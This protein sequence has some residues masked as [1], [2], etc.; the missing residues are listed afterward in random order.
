[1]VDAEH[2]GGVVPGGVCLLGG[3]PGI[4]KST[5]LLQVLSA[6][7]D[8]SSTLYVTGE[9]SLAQVHLRAQRLG[10]RNLD[11]PVLAETSVEQILAQLA[12][13]KPAFV[14]VDSVQTLYTEA[15]E[16]APGSVSQ[17]RESAAQLVRHA[18]AHQTAIVLVGH[19]T[20]DGAIAGPRV[21]EHMV[22]TV[23]YFEH[24]PGSRYRIVR[25]IKNR[26]GAVNELGVFAMTD[27]G[28]KE[29]SNPSALFLSRHGDP[30]PG[31]VITVARQGSRP[32]LVEV[33]ALV[34]RSLAG[35]PRRV[36]LGLENNRLNMLLAVL[37]R[38]GGIALSD[39]D[40][41]ANVVGGMR[42]HETAADLP[43]LMA[44][45]SS[46]RSRPWPGDTVV[47]GE[48]GLA[49]EVRPVAGGEERLAEAAKQGF[50][51]AIVPEGNRPRRGAKLDLEI[52]AVGR[53][54]QALERL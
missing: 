13:L 18:K 14:V 36:T 2:G 3:D 48:V 12:Q 34:D 17:L 44:A 8:R 43:L 51:R 50:R 47:F 1:M 42:I 25:A 6:L 28:L 20:K 37:H 4:G 16:S 24:D 19:V 23:L 52:E 9:E 22:D 7:Q 15:L 26:F 27:A 54:S 5:L 46:F 39:Q 38:H 45:L 29:V 10:L 49:G 21:L 41:Y 30:V 35:S 11:V 31:S 33:Q 53:L 32:L 40:V